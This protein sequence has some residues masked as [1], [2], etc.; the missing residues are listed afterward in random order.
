MPARLLLMLILLIHPFRGAVAVAAEPARAGDL[1]GSVCCP[2]C[3]ELVSCPCEARDNDPM[4]MPEPAAPID[5]AAAAALPVMV[6]AAVPTL[7]VG[8]A[9]ASP[10]G[11]PVGSLRSLDA[12]V[13]AFLS[14]V[15]VWTN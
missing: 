1:C 15:C 9:D 14:R 4:P 2:L 11:P 6:G 12:T 10:R 13:G 7:G 3:A 8:V 5:R